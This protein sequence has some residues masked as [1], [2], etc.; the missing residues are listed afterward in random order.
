MKK[1]TLMIFLILS[2]C[3]CS[4]NDSVQAQSA[5]TLA[6]E[7]VSQNWGGLAAGTSFNYGGKENAL[8]E[9]LAYVE[10][11]LRVKNISSKEEVIPKWIFLDKNNH[12]FKGAS[13][14]FS[15]LDKERKGF[16]TEDV[17]VEPNES[18]L[19]YLRSPSNFL[20]YLKQREPLYIADIEHKSKWSVDNIP[21]ALV[22]FK[23]AIKTGC[24]HSLKVTI[25]D[26]QWKNIPKG[27]EIT[28]NEEKFNL[29]EDMMVADLSIRVKNVAENEVAIPPL[30]L[31][32]KDKSPVARLIFNNGATTSESGP[33]NVPAG[34]SIVV[35]LEMAM[36]PYDKLVSLEP[37]YI[38]DQNLTW[39]LE[40]DPLT[41]K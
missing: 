28:S 1:Y 41:Q 33:I 26:Q 29:N 25:E 19:I 14:F 16:I 10:V 7:L 6:V 13:G 18:L 31:V 2:L 21:D 34:S 20:N 17:T 38:S 8:T 12:Q 4:T 40:L 15:L 11:S 37:L 36:E 39:P 23:E 30:F 32:D 9:D 5:E 35:K 27:S 22:L 3:S 24:Y